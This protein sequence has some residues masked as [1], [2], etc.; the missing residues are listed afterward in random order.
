MSFYNVERAQAAMRDHGFVALL[1]QSPESVQ[2]HAGEP[3]FF[4]K[5][6]RH[7]H[8]AA[9]IDFVDTGLPPAMV[10]SNF[11][12]EPLRRA[13]AIND[14]RTY[15][16]WIAIDDA[17][18]IMHGE[19]VERPVQP[20]A[21]AFADQVRA[22]LRDRRVDAGLIGVEVS[23]MSATAWEL[24]QERLSN[25]TLVPADTVFSQIRAVKT[26]E[27]V[28]MLRTAATLTEIGIDGALSRGVLDA[29]HQDLCLAYQRT[30]LDYALQHN[31]VGVTGASP[32][33]FNIGPDP[34]PVAGVPDRRGTKGDIV[35]LDAGV[36]VQGYRSDLGRTSVL[37]EP[38][39]LQERLAR[40]LLQGL[41]AALGALKP[42]RPLRE[43]FHAGVQVVRSAGF[44][45]YAR[46]HLGHAIGLAHREDAPFISANDETVAEPG[47]TFAVELPYYVSNLGAMLF[48]E[49]VVITPNGWELLT[50]RRCAFNVLPV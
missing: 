43:A 16:T 46:G 28:Q 42:G 40:A 17:S 49:N 20:A 50:H 11:E 32:I 10:V 48:E 13:V 6:L 4:N 9:S 22:V 24:L 1:A 39:E 23:A 14:V 37:I 2:Y 12:A 18:E 29:T 33:N 47:M 15:M 44:T 21:A 30:V 25:F 36:T 27:E 38:S 35:K 5:M 8:A 45:R 34:F 31:I 19:P 3:G 7:G 26:P 41:E